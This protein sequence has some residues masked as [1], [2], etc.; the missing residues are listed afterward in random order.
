[1]NGHGRRRYAAELRA[2]ARSGLEVSEISHL[3]EG[4][5][6]DCTAC[7]LMRAGVCMTCAS[8]ITAQILERGRP[9]TIN[10]SVCSGACRE[11]VER[12]LAGRRS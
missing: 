10:V 12:Y 2:L 4:W 6:C 11:G 7:R 9:G 8:L 3:E 5:D 1:M